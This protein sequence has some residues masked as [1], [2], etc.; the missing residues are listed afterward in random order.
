[1]AELLDD[2]LLNKYFSLAD[3][4]D[5]FDLCV[6]HLLNLHDLSVEGV[7]VLNKSLAVLL[8]Y[9]SDKVV[10]TIGFRECLPDSS[11]VLLLLSDTCE[12]LDQTH[13]SH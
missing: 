6:R 1:M 12:N 3:I 10:G 13:V 9:W 8:L 7:I 2:F 11:G 5:T 4:F